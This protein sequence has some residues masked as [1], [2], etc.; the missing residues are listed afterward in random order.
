MKMDVRWRR[1]RGCFANE[2]C[3]VVPWA[4]GGR[5]HWRRMER[6]APRVKIGCLEREWRVWV[7]GFGDDMGGLVRV[8]ILLV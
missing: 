5:D 4:K 7:G 6:W 1:R 8:G 3:W 2:E